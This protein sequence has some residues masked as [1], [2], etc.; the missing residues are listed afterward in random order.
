MSEVKHIDKDF[1]PFSFFFFNY[2]SLTSCGYDNNKSIV[3]VIHRIKQGKKLLHVQRNLVNVI[4][5][6]EYCLKKSVHLHKFCK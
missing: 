5:C 1:F 3:H 4:T 6:T 2:M